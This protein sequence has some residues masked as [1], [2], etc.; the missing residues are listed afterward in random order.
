MMDGIM[1]IINFAVVIMLLLTGCTTPKK[2]KETSST[3]LLLN[4]PALTEPSTCKNDNVYFYPQPIYKANIYNNKIFKNPF[5]PPLSIPVTGNITTEKSLRHKEYLWFKTIF[6]S[7]K[8]PHNEIIDKCLKLHFEE[9]DKPN[10]KQLLVMCD[11]TNKQIKKTN[12]KF[13]IWYSEVLRLAGK[14]KK[15]IKINKTLA[16]IIKKKQVPIFHRFIN[17]LNQSKNLKKSYRRK[18]LAMLSKFLHKNKLERD[19]YVLILRQIRRFR[20]QKDTW[21][22]LYKHL[23]KEDSALPRWFKLIIMGNHELNMAS[24]NR[25]KALKARWSKDFKNEDIYWKEFKKHNQNAAGFFRSAWPIFPRCTEAALGM[26]KTYRPECTEAQNFLNNISGW[27][28]IAVQGQVDFI[29]AYLVLLKALRSK[30]YAESRIMKCAE[31]ALKTGLFNTR[32]P[33]MYLFGL[34]LAASDYR[35]AWQATFRRQR[36]INNLKYYFDNKLKST[37]SN[38]EKELLLARQAQIY[39]LCGLYKQVREILKKLPADYPLE[40]SCDGLYFDYNFAVLKRNRQQIES[41]IAAYNGPCS[42]LLQQADIAIQ[43]GC[44]PLTE[45]FLKLA[46]KQEINT[47]AKSY[48]LAR[49]AMRSAGRDTEYNTT[50]QD[51]ILYCA[52]KF[53][54]DVIDTL[55]KYGLDFNQIT[56]SGR[57]TLSALLHKK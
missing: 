14:K 19:K 38:K 8:S 15:A 28:N 29:P 5:F 6:L 26:M 17:L 43:K 12:Y 52:S 32:V 20:N 45:E 27:F 41:E 42:K 44:G 57:Y 51:L 35:F 36:V 56:S 24:N 11:K 4:N 31:T 25:I 13:L 39:R 2:E 40:K 30:S 37:V 22:Q 47:P 54:F 16:K 34:I 53:R 23:K 10:L 1:K 49:L 48:I 9:E 7:S 18:A 33:D 46:L 3:T 50:P 21:E 55:A